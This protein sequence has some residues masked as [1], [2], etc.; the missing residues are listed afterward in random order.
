MLNSPQPPESRLPMSGGLALLLVLGSLSLP[1]FLQAGENGGSLVS[2]GCEDFMAGALPPPGTKVFINYLQFY[3][4]DQLKDNN[5]NSTGAFRLNV[6]VDALRFIDVFKT[7]VLGAD[8][9]LHVIIPVLYEHLD[10]SA[11]SMSIADQGRAGVG[12]IEFGTGLAYH[13]TSTFHHVLGL[14]AVAPTGQYQRPDSDN[15]N[16]IVNIGRNYWGLDPI[17]A[18]TYL[19]D[20]QSPIPGLEASAKFMYWFNTQNSATDYRSGDEFAF[21]YLVGYHRGDWALLPDLR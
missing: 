5:G 15:N 20:T 16:D 8:P 6:A 2:V 19:G 13:P 7:K 11:G 3:S 9:I 1:G 14:D 18:L 12:D 4:A 21:D 17:W 10:F